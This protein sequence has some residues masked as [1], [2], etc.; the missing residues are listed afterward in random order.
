LDLVTKLNI[1]RDT[2]SISLVGLPNWQQFTNMD[3]EILSNLKAHLLVPSFVNYEDRN[4]NSFI[5]KFRR[6]YLTEPSDYA[7]K[8]FDVCWY[9]L[10]ALKN[11]GNNFENCLPYYSP[12]YIQTEMNF[13]R[14]RG[15]DGFE[16]R[17]W[18]VLKYDRYRL[19]EVEVYPPEPPVTKDAQLL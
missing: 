3:N 19:K 10:N 4:T 9:F 5:Y 2:F 17:S 16:N 18:K 15:G 6:R 1:E 13:E 14:V 11:F 8:G 7:F 12:W